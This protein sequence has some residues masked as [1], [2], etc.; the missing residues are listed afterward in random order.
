MKKT[1]W[2]LLGILVC[3]FALPSFAAHPQKPGRWEI[4]Q[5]IDMPGA[6]MKIP[7]TTRTVCV[8]KEDIEKN[9]EGTIP[10]PRKRGGDERSDCKISDYKVDGNTVS[11]SMKC[12]GENPVTGSGKMTYEKESFKGVTE[13]HMSRGDFKVTMSGKYLGGEC[14]KDEKK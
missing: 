5:E 14:S 10:K 12:E 8:T 1:M 3:A 2:V 7:P 13:M 4:T 11:W 6:P 9:P